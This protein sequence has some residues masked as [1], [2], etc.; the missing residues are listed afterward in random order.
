M[1]YQGTP[2]LPFPF[3]LFLPTLHR[4]DYKGSS[5]KA[6]LD[7]VLAPREPLAQRGSR[8]PAAHTSDPSSCTLAPALL[9]TGRSAHSSVPGPDLSPGDTVMSQSQTW[10]CRSSQQGGRKR[11]SQKQLRDKADG[12]QEVTEGHSGR[13]GWLRWL[14]SERAREL[15]EER[16][17]SARPYSQGYG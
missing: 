6:D 9:L 10:P 17:P 13:R 3:P 4:L 1:S 14:L 11:R 12:D 7:M 16:G 15:P 5:Y 8:V 2:F